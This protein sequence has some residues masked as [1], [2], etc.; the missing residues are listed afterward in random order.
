[1]RKTELI[2]KRNKDIHTYYRS[3]LKRYPHWRHDYVIKRVADKFYLT[4][5]TIEHILFEQKQTDNED[6]TDD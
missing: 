3:L 6:N 5:R 4:E 1:M 2:Q